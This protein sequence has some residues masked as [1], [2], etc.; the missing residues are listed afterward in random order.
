MAESA[1]VVSLFENTLARPLVRDE[2]EKHPLT[3]REMRL[4][5]IASREPYNEKTIPERSSVSE[6]RPFIDPVFNMGVMD[7]AIGGN[8]SK[9]FNKFVFDKSISG[10][11][12]S[13]IKRLLLYSHAVVINDPLD[14][15]LDFFLHSGDSELPDFVK[16]RI[17][18]ANSL[19]IEFAGMADLIRNEILI[20]VPFC[21][22]DLQHMPHLSQESA[23]SIAASLEGVIPSKDVHRYQR[24]VQTLV[25]RHISFDGRA[26]YFF[27]EEAYVRVLIEVLRKLGRKFVSDDMTFQLNSSLLARLDTINV[28]SLRMDE[29]VNIRKNDQTFEDWRKF[30]GQALEETAT[31]EGLTGSTGDE[32]HLALRKQLENKNNESVRNIIQS[33]WAKNL[34]ASLVDISIGAISGAVPAALMSNDSPLSGAI[35]GASK[36]IITGLAK[37]F[38]P[39]ANRK[40]NAALRSHYVA[41]GSKRHSN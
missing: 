18:A 20:T 8:L 1:N 6:I 19:L 40:S 5:A 21:A 32:F 33:N 15:I 25:E 31:N 36:D 35:S 17:G 14:Y 41:L 27:P 9:D 28:D 30:L 3:A 26:D 24:I 2:L 39:I 13:S 22:T 7:Y 34:G 4:L 38:S 10:R 11:M 16:G 29:I 37:L 12:T 23:T